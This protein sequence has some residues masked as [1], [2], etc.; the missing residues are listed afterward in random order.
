MRLRQWRLSLRLGGTNPYPEAPTT[1]PLVSPL[2]GGAGGNTTGPGF[3]LG[4]LADCKGE[5]NP[6]PNPLKP[7]KPLP[8][9]YCALTTATK[10]AMHRATA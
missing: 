7:L 3:S 5:S 8:K 9:P 1:T 10:Q 2:S 6:L 4:S